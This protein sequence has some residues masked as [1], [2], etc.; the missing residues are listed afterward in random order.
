VRGSRSSNY[1]R[2][3][4]SLQEVVGIT[5]GPFPVAISDESVVDYIA[6]TGD[7]VERWARHAPPSYAAALLFAVAP[8][9]LEDE[10]VRPYTGVLIHVDQEF[11]WNAPLPI[12][13]KT[14]VGGRV[15]N[16]RERGGS[17]FVTFSCWVDSESGERLIDSVSTFLMG[18]GSPP[19]SGDDSPEPAVSFRELNDP[20]PLS[21]R[22]E[23]GES[24][25]VNKS[26]SRIDLVKYA[27]A[28]GDY[29]PIHFDR[30]AARSA[31]LDG[32]VVHGL[33]MSAWGLQVAAAMS[34]RPDP[35]VRT[36]IRF[37]N[38]LRPAAPARVEV[39]ARGDCDDGR[40]V[41]FEVVSEGSRLATANCVVN[42]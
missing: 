20:P 29:N 14:S 13:T 24:L 11:C 3:P 17:L 27:A 33:L 42:R 40:R 23:D 37:R 28:S 21:L 4:M 31:G 26:A 1:P 10:R 16:V 34:D 2:S 35:L 39:T 30:E 19:E 41:A 36:K 8:S 7:A 22:L 6:A 38:P 18:A 25:S 9:F 32:I 5:Y 15:D 12:G